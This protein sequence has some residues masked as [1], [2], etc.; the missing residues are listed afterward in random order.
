MIK[1]IQYRD[2]CIGCNACVEALSTRWRMSKKDGKSI[3][4]GGQKK[5]HTYS[6]LVHEYEYDANQ[7]AV[8]NCPVKLIQISQTNR[9]NET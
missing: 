8:K 5:G 9:S 1:I 6:V 7:K 4:I 3:L 2:K